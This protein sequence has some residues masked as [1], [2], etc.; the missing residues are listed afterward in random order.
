MHRRARGIVALRSDGQRRN[1]ETARSRARRPGSRA[2]HS[3][4]RRAMLV[5]WRRHAK[6]VGEDREEVR[7]FTLATARGR[8]ICRADYRSAFP[9]YRPGHEEE[10]EEGIEGKICGVIEVRCAA[11]RCGEQRL[12]IELAGNIGNEIADRLAVA[13]ICKGGLWGAS[14]STDALSGETVRRFECST[15]FSLFVSPGS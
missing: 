6:S 2:A 11:D 9:R 13:V 3:P 10:I 5:R 12:V 4:R 8:F 7:H 15:S 1:R 14:C